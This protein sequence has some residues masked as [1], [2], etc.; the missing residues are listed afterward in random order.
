MSGRNFSFGARK[1]PAVPLRALLVCFAKVAR[2]EIVK[3]WGLASCIAGTRIT[4]DVLKRYGVEAVSIPVDLFACNAAYM[5]AVDA[6]DQPPTDK[7]ALT[8]WFART[9]AWSAGT[10]IAAITEHDIHIVEDYV[11]P[12]DPVHDWIPVNMNMFPQP[13]KDGDVV[14]L[15]KRGY[16]YYDESA[17]ECLSPIHVGHVVAH[18][19]KHSLIVDASADQVDE[20]EKG[21]ELPSVVVINSNRRFLNG[22]E[23]LIGDCN[24]GCF[25]YKRTD[26]ETY[27]EAEIWRDKS[28]T[29]HT[30]ESICAGIERLL[31]TLQMAG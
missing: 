10:G 31:G 11:P 18:L 12:G 15:G 28:K 23:L 9:G 2:T 8:E 17:G 6:G 30:R 3:D 13:L 25:Q 26:N 27:R 19:P 24:G 20:P 1:K 29:K 14:M 5:K 22:E 16:R 4:I 7:R 21:I